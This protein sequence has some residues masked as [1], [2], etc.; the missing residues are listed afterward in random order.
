MR[1]STMTWGTK[2]LSELPQQIGLVT[3][4]SEN[5]VSKIWIGSVQS[6]AFDDFDEV[7]VCHI[8]ISV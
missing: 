5:N 4:G 8:L 2:A 6:R 3:I 1:S 7:R